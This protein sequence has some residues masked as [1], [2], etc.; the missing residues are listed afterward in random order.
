MRYKYV[1]KSKIY[2]FLYTFLSM[3]LLKGKKECKELFL[4]YIL[5]NVKKKT[6]KDPFLIL[7]TI[8]L[9]FN[10][11][12]KI[13]HLKIGNLNYKIAVSIKKTSKRKINCK[14]LLS[15]VKHLDAG[16]NFYSKI[17]KEIILSFDSSSKTLKAVETLYTSVESNKTIFY[18]KI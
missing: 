2:C 17:I 5:A 9:K 18:S 4:Q 16:K 7:H 8:L 6:K 15:N 1:D 12:C 14:T 13:K 10:V 11:L 3:F